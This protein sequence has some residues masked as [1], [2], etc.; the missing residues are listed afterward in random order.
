[1]HVGVHDVGDKY[2]LEKTTYG[3]RNAGDSS[4]HSILLFLLVVCIQG[5]TVSAGR[6]LHRVQSRG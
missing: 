3:K 5:M 1:M 2:K 6:G 4:L